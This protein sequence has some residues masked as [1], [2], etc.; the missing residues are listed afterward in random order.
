LNNTIANW[1][2]ESSYKFDANTSISQWAYEFLRRN[3][4]YKKDVKEYIRLCNDFR[5]GFNP[6]IKKS[7]ESNDDIFDELRH[8]EPALNAG[9]SESKWLQRLAAIG[10]QG[11]STPLD[12][13]YSEKWGLSTII[14]PYSEYNSISVRFINTASKVRIAGPNWFKSEK[15]TKITTSKKQAFIIDYS[16]P[17]SNQLAA[18][19]RHVTSHYKWLKNNGHVEKNSNKRERTKLY[20]IYLRCLDAVDSG[21]QHTEIAKALCPTKTNKY[22]D[23]NGSKTVSDW[24]KAA[25]ELRTKNYI[26]LPLIKSK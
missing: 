4:D 24:V 13:W 25:E 15:I 8:Y 26:Y 16:L 19:K 3:H 11:T 6:F 14:D 12:I 23:M 22:P 17:L 5:S 2:D 1:T 7:N 20:T 18:I 9:E 10:V 21:A